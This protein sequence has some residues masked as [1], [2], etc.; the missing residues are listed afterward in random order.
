MLA[1]LGTSAAQV[2]GVRTIPVELKGYSHQNPSDGQDVYNQ[3]AYAGFSNQPQFVLQ[4]TGTGSYQLNEF[5]GQ[6]NTPRYRLDYVDLAGVVYPITL[7]TSTT[8]PAADSAGSTGTKTLFSARSSDAQAVD[9][10][11][12]YTLDTVFYVVPDPAN[13]DLSTLQVAQGIQGMVNCILYEDDAMVYA[14]DETCSGTSENVN[15]GAA[16]ALRIVLLLP[17]HPPASPFPLP[18]NPPAPPPLPPIGALLWSVPDSL[19]VG[20][21]PYYFLFEGQKCTWPYQA[22][23]TQSECANVMSN[24]GTALMSGKTSLPL[25]TNAADIQ[26]ALNSAIGSTTA[27]VFGCFFTVEQFDSETVVPVYFTSVEDGLPAWATAFETVTPHVRHVCSGPPLA[28]SFPPQDVPAPPQSPLPPTLPPPPLSLV[29]SL[30]GLGCSSIQMQARGVNAEI[31]QTRGECL[32]AVNWFNS[33]YKQLIT[34]SVQGDLLSTYSNSQLDHDIAHTATSGVNWPG[35]FY[36]S[37]WAASPDGQFGTRA[38]F[39]DYVPGDPIPTALSG[40]T[41]ICRL[42]RSP[43]P[44]PPSPPPPR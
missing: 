39:Q 43:S 10:L 35:C 18:P 12:D 9:S 16:N 15:N 34:P 3:L 32:D 25:S 31:I 11:W 8:S 42:S 40:F 14:T 13:P 28:P 7:S 33:N 20:S 23:Y 19:N 17:P 36:D 6:D 41:N 24:Y 37:D 44:P 2:D 4:E 38:Y 21:M 27:Y 30:D 22:V 29:V 26:S 1:L 5:L